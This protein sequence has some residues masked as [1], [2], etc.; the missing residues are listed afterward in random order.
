V[1]AT[2]AAKD[3]RDPKRPAAVAKRKIVELRDR[4]FGEAR[5]DDK[6]LPRFRA[7]CDADGYPLVGNVATKG[8]D[9]MRQPSS[10]CA[11]VRKIER[12][13]EHETE[14]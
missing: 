14:E 4:L 10:V 3:Q 12:P 11:R 5:V 7:L 9:A 1:C 2:I 13:H 6:T 8:R